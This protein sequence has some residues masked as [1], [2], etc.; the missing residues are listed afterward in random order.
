MKTLVKTTLLLVC[1]LILISSS[2]KKE[3]TGT[4]GLPAATQEGKNTFGCLVNGNVF[5][6]KP[7]GSP[8]RKVEY[9]AHMDILII[10]YQK[11]TTF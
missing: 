10:M 1:N 2:C 11:I 3:K 5:V 7:Y 9:L 8:P 6:A 4:D